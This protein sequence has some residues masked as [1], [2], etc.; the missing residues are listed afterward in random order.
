MEAR[1]KFLALV[2]VV[3]LSM[4][5]DYRPTNVGH[6]TAN[7]I[8][9]AE[10]PGFAQKV[11]EQAEQYRRDLAIK[12]LGHE[13]PQWPEPCPIRVQ[14]QRGA[15]GETSFAFVPG[16][17]GDRPTSWNMIVRG[18][19]ER[20]LDAVLPH[21]ITHTIFATHFGRP[22]PRWADEG[23]C[24]SVEHSSEKVKQH[25]LLIEA[26][27][28]NR[29]IPFNKMYR[30]REYP[31]DILPLY[32]QGFSVAKFLI[33]QRGHQHFVHYIGEGMQTERW[34]EATDR[35]YGF[36]DLSDLQ[37]SW[38]DWVKLGSDTTAVSVRSNGAQGT[39]DADLN[40]Q[41]GSDRPATSSVGSTTPVQPSAHV[42][43]QITAP[44][45]NELPNSI[46]GWYF[47]QLRDSR[48]AQRTFPVSQKPAPMTIPTA[49]ETQSRRISPL[50]YVYAPSPSFR[51]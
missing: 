31:N 45:G 28:H 4:G 5:A 13:L 29:G 15:S 49:T 23:A 30:M 2:G 16:S 12:W 14:F 36:D 48:P 41:G 11:G 43:Q 18:T 1:I 46:G 22:L 9:S 39:T 6:R 35:F 8:I 51:R 38:L 24:T 25:N 3:T 27:T 20:V 47:D 33:A 17:R 40:S 37:L 50:E 19:P 10:D 34:D 32:A 44:Q 26:L 21:E 42:N 7:F